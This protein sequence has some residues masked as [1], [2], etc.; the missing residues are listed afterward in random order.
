[1]SIERVI[2]QVENALDRLPY[3]ETHHDQVELAADRQQK[4]LKYLEIRE[5]TL[6]EEKSRMVALP[7]SSYHYVNDRETSSS[8]SEPS[9]LP[10]FPSENYDPCSEYRNKRKNQKV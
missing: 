2:Q 1:M 8:L 3:V 6:Q 10:Y 7:S 4:R 9:S 5:G